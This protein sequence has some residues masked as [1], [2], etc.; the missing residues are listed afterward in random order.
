MDLTNGMGLEPYFHGL[1]SRTIQIVV[2]KASWT[3]FLGLLRTD[4]LVSQWI[5][6]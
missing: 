4:S 6:R 5:D 1:G 2:S 3:K